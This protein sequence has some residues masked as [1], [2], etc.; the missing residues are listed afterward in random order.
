MKTVYSIYIYIYIYTGI[1]KEKDRREEIEYRLSGES[2]HNI[3]GSPPTKV[4]LTPP[5][6]KTPNVPQEKAPTEPSYQ[7]LH[8]LVEIDSTGIRYEARGPPNMEAT[9]T[10]CVKTQTKANEGMDSKWDPVWEVEIGDGAYQKL[11]LKVREQLK[12]VLDDE[13]HKVKEE[14]TH[15]QNIMNASM[16]YMRVIYILYIYIIYIERNQEIK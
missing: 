14:F 15:K 3:S 5:L 11:P 8:K 12:L 2:K 6:P 16:N 4:P 7:V 13:V 9:E 10:R 1:R